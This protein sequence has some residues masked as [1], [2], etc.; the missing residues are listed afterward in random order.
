MG[1]VVSSLAAP[2]TPVDSDS[3]LEAVGLLLS[4][5]VVAATGFR[6][7]ELAGVGVLILLLFVVLSIRTLREGPHATV[8]PNNSKIQVFLTT[9]KYRTY[10]TLVN[11]SMCKSICSIDSIT[12][13]V[14]QKIVSSAKFLQFCV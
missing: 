12:V 5:G 4:I 6:G 14:C 1:L 3:G 7:F 11:N 9:I 8:A 13:P 10:Y 2:G